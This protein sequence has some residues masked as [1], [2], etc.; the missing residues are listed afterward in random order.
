MGPRK[1]WARS[2]QELLPTGI[3]EG[4][5]AIRKERSKV[6]GFTSV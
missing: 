2:G 3:A 1:E 4:E 5:T 6:L